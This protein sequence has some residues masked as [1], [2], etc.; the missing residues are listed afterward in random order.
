MRRFLAR[1]VAFLRPGLAERELE[2]E[3]TSHLALLE[4]D[5]QRRGM[6][7]VDARMAARRAY[8]GVELA[9]ELHRDTRSFRWLEEFLR[10]L[11]HAARG[12]SRSP[13]FA[14]LSVLTLALGVG[15]NTTVFTAYN[16]LAL[17][18]LP[19]ADPERVVRLERWFE[20]RNLGDI[21]YAFSYPE[22]VYCRDHNNVFGAM[23]AGSYNL[24]VAAR[25]DAEPEKIYGQLVSGNFFDALGV[26][27][28]LGRTFLP[29]EDRAPGANPVLVISHSFWQHRFHADPGVLGRKIEIDSM[30]YTVI[31]VAAHDFVSTAVGD[32]FAQF[33]APLS[34]QAQLAPP[35]RWADD[36]NERDV[37]ILGRLKPGI[38]PGRAQAETSVLIRQ[39]ARTYQER[40]RTS[41]VTLQH[42]AMLGNTEDIRFQAVVAGILM[43]VGLVLLVACANIANMLLARAAGRQREIGVRLSLGAGRGRMIRHLLTESLLLSFC[44]GV[45]GLLLASWS[46]RLLTVSAA[47]MIAGTP[48]ANAGFTLDLSLDWRVFAYAMGISLTAGIVFGLAPAL[49][50]TRPDLATALKE[51]GSSFG[52]QLTRSRLRGF[53]VGAQVAVSMLLLIIA[54]LLLRGLVKSHDADPG[55][56]ARRIFLLAADFPAGQSADARDRLVE[57][58]RNVPELSSAATGDYPMMGTW[59]PPVVVKK[60]GSQAPLRDRTLASLG[61][62]TYLDTLGIPLVRGRNLTA[63]EARSGAPLSV[64]SESAARR[65]WGGEDPIGKT[66]QLDLDFNGKLTAFEVIG[67]VKD[68]RFANLTRLDPAHVYLPPRSNRQTG[69]LLRTQGDPRRAMA[70]IRAAVASYD[71]SLLPGLWLTSVQDGPMLR[72]KSQART[73]AAFAGILASLALLL[74]GVGIY[75]VMSYLMSQRVRE[76][77]V[78]MALG[79]SGGAILRSVVLRGLRPV[80][81]GIAAG[82]LG[83]A[84]LS[85]LL[86]TTLVFPGSTD[87]LYG[88]PFYDPATFAG[89]TVF[90]SGVAALAS[91]VPARRAVRFDPMRALRWE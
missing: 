82:M 89:L 45:T 36:P 71:R 60:A 61:N 12:L 78:R 34:M 1:C 27:A 85:A 38:P 41:A 15:V 26:S 25:I 48:A 59:T 9:K 39:F 66:F 74:A 57:R 51:E 30:A 5:F 20:N 2:R 62:E 14:A 28:Q 65:F 76:I 32:P 11:R 75:G 64:I 81:C 49:Q 69:I 84:G 3:V 54:G 80:I 17:R 70:A 77:G 43:L 16:A 90:V 13:G 88:V 91:F 73:F 58:L 22:Y 53:L 42:T 56:D 23:T 47:Q 29:E 86:H 72:E 40:D 52:R 19:V 21:Q 31:G 8:G 55:F 46:T 4:E 37:Q 50:C 83:A 6:S 67:I 33:W 79:A 24:S 44:G 7:P 68:I 10:D 63:Q 18:P 35:R 87:V